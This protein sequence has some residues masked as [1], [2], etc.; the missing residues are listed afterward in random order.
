MVR[1]NVL[2]GDLDF[3]WYDFLKQKFGG[4]PRFT[5][6]IRLMGNMGGESVKEMNLATGSSG[7]ALEQQH[8]DYVKKIGFTCEN[9][10]VDY[11]YTYRSSFCYASRPNTFIFRPDGRISK[12]SVILEDPRNCVGKIDPMQGVVI[13]EEKN[14]L[15]HQNTIPEKCISCKELLSCMNKKCPRNR[16]LADSD[17][18]C[19]TK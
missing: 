11:S 17:C 19:P 3:T 14:K 7:K 6:L 16:I 12:C 2:A 13:D 8:I 1:H 15:W 18:C 5:M 10:A 4:D 9:D